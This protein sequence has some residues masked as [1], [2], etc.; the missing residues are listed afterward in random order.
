MQPNSLDNDNNQR[1]PAFD[2]AVQR[3]L[4]GLRN[5][6]RKYAEKYHYKAG[7]EDLLQTTLV[8]ILTS[9]HTF[10]GASYEPGGGFYKWVSWRMR[11]VCSNA[12]RER[13]PVVYKFADQATP[14]A[15]EHATELALTLDKLA[16]MP[17][18]LSSAVLRTAAGIGCAEQAAAYGLTPAG[19]TERTRRGRRE[20]TG[21]HVRRNRFAG[22][23]R[24]RV[25]A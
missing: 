15:Q 24:E 20:L 5:L 16:A 21:E 13:E 22:R 7:A 12:R 11:G 14:P 17:E 25:A 4:P 1:P 19:I 18:E 6:A 3:Y 2:A 23:K 8:T 9:W 10:R